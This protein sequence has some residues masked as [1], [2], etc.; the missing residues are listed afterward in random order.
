MSMTSPAGPA[1]SPR[2]RRL[3]RSLLAAAVLAP[4]AGFAVFTVTSASA[5]TAPIRGTASNRCIDVPNASRTNGTQ[6]VLWDCNGGANQTWNTTS[7]RQIQVYGSKCLDAEGAGTAAGTRVVI[8]DC[9]G[10]TNQQWDVNTNGTITNVRSG[11]CLDANG[12]GTANGTTIVLWNCTGS[13]NQRWTQS[14]G[15]TG[16]GGSGTP[17]IDVSYPVTREGAYGTN[18][19]TIFRPSN[20]A[21]VGRALPVLVFANGGC[22]HRLNGSFVRA[23]TFVASHG[24]VVVNIGSIDGSNVGVQDG[25]VLPWL[26]TDGIGWAQRENGRTGAALAG[27][28]D[29]GK[30]AVA[31]HSCG[32]LEALVAGADSR[33]RSVISFN[34]GLFADGAF[35]YRRTELNRLHSPVLFMDGGPSDVAYDNSRANYS[36]TRV[37]AVMASQS[38]AGHSGWFDGYRGSRGDASMIT[39][40]MTTAVQWLDFTLNGNQTARGYFLGSRPGLSTVANWQVSSKNF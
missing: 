22:N 32:G 17:A 21:A 24:F 11:L 14:G 3:T 31:G 25:V 19:Y 40:G 29:L 8:G 10:G 27:R 36:L 4:I 2:R 13:T 9:T 26:L 5:A 35:G 28:L 30:V 18:R 1:R 7:S 23:M 20:P 6:V 34:S 12:A 38:Q 39:E 37:P 16:G 33:V 15:G